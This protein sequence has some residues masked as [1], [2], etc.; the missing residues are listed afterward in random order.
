MNFGTQG[1]HMRVCDREINMIKEY[2]G[3]IESVDSH[4]RSSIE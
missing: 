1:Q 4:T 3:R 2:C